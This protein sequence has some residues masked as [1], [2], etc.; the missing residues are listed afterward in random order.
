MNKIYAALSI[1]MLAA[2]PPSRAESLT[3]ASLQTAIKVREAK[4]VAGETPLSRLTMNQRRMRLGLSFAPIQAE[5]LPAPTEAAEAIL[6][7]SF[8]WREHDAVSGVRDQKTCGSCWAFAMTQALESYIMITQKTSKDVS[9]SEQ[10]LI[11]CGGKG[12]CDGGILNA[13]FLQA[14]GLPPASDYPYTAT[15]GSCVMAQDGWKDRATKIGSWHAVEQD[16]GAIKTALVTY[17]PL[18]TAFSVYE[19]FMYY[20]SGVYSYIKG[21]PLGGHAVLLVGYNDDE[22]YFIVKNSWG[23]GWGEGGYFRIAYSEMDSA[24]SFGDSTIVYLTVQSAN[25]LSLS[26]APK[27][28]VSGVQAKLPAEE[29]PAAKPAQPGEDEQIDRDIHDLDKS[30][31]DMEKRIQGGGAQR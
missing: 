17:G 28:P 9:L 25:P 3:V 1:L 29:K 26:A 20:K 22:Q 5:P 24:V 19:D 10:V 12:S 27:A 14:T 13:D 2:C 18:A 30:G 15:D 6:P 16:L 7:K 8:D 23:P 4:W 11:S 21:K 31:K